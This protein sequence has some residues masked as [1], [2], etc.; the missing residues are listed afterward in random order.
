MS[1]WIK[2]SDRLPGD[3]LDGMAVIVAVMHCRRG[4]IA[5]TDIWHKGNSSGRH[6]KGH[7]DFWTNTATHWQPLPTPPE[8]AQ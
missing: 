4:F 1:G 5:E 3:D 8:E 6:P 7:F 2:C